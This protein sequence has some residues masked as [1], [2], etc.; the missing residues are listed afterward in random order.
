MGPDKV[1]FQVAGYACPVGMGLWSPDL[2]EYVSRKFPFYLQDPNIPIHIKEFVC[3]ILSVKLRGE[4]WAGE[5]CQL[6]CDNNADS[7]VNLYMKPK[8]P[9]IQHYP[10]EFFYWVC[11]LNFHPIV[12][13]I[14]T[15]EKYVADF[16]S[17]NFC[18]NDAQAFFR[19]QNLQPLKPIVI[20]NNYFDLV[21]VW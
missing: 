7:D 10:R 4:H 21:A 17:R 19:G 14:G 18:P 6:F 9:Q 5:V 3:L 1:A 16:L 11:K 2:Q 20:S 12:L 15:K 13:K 8:D